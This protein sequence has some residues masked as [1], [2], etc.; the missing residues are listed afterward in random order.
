ME[1]NNCGEEGGWTRIGFV[2]MSEP[3]TTCPTGL[4]EGQYDNIGLNHTV[5][6]DILFQCSTIIF[7]IPI[8]F[9]FLLSPSTVARPILGTGI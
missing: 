5:F 9:C 7:H 6:N 1:G 2:N 8:P 3:G 4:T